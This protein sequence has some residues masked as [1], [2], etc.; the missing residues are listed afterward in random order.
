MSKNTLET[1]EDALDQLTAPE[2]LKLIEQLARSLRVP[3]PT[4]APDQKREAL[5]QLRKELAA[6]PVANPADGFSGRDHD[7]ALY[8]GRR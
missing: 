1:I 7:Q 6:L 8:G 3:P 4:R 5:N 2:K